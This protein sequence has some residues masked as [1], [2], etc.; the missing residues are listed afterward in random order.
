MPHV[1][2]F[3]LG[4]T[5][6]PRTRKTGIEVGEN[7]LTG[8]LECCQLKWRVEDAKGSFCR[9]CFGN[10]TT[11]WNESDGVGWKGKGVKNESYKRGQNR[12]TRGGEFA[13]RMSSSWSFDSLPI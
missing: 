1:S 9:T 4:G 13:R 5:S 11:D 7:R 3:L 2:N 10:E 8:Y 12:E 6:I